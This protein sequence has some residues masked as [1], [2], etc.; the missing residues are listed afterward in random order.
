MFAKVSA[1]RLRAF[2]EKF[3]RASVKKV[4]ASIFILLAVTFFTVFTRHVCSIS[5]PVKLS[6]EA[7]HDCCGSEN[8]QSPESCHDS[9][10]TSA[11]H[12]PCCSAFFIAHIFTVEPSVIAVPATPELFDTFAGFSQPVPKR[13]PIA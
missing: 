2:D 6:L 13:P 12:S 7:P 11:S 1:F 3:S 9:H 8:R 4:R 5:H 10:E